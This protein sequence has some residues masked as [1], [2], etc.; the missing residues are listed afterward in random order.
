MKSRLLILV[1]TLSMTALSGCGTIAN[2]STMKPKVYGGLAYD[3]NHLRIPGPLLPGNYSGASPTGGLIYV[4]VL[5]GVVP[6]EFCCTAVGDTLTLPITL[7][8]DPDWPPPKPE[9]EPDFSKY[10][11]QYSTNQP[12]TE[13]KV[14]Y[15]PYKIANTDEHTN[16]GNVEPELPVPDAP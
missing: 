16:R 15:L 14:N 4:A 10:P 6:A 11:V 12:T 9:P 8:V 3:A 5:M 1:A 13:S 2:F 7:L